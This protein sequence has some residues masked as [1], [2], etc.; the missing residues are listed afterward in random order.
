[1]VRGCQGTTSADRAEYDEIRSVIDSI[2]WPVYIDHI[3]G[4][5]FPSN[6]MSTSPE[7]SRSAVH[8]AGI[9]TERVISDIIADL[10]GGRWSVIGYNCDV[11]SVS[12]TEN[13]TLIL[14]QVQW[15]EP[16]L[17]VAYARRV[18]SPQPAIEAPNPICP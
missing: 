5:G 7:Y 18:D 12:I 4:G 11:P 17:I 3:D 13:E 2:E 10:D 8:D 1:M 14:V 6:D 9:R 16:F 15:V